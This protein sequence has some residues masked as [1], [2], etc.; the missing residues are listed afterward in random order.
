MAYGLARDL[1]RRLGEASTLLKTQPEHLGR[2]IETLLDENRRL[3]KRVEELL[4]GGGGGTAGGT[5]EQI[6]DVELHVDESDLDDRDQIALTMDAFR[7]KKRSAIRVLFTTG[8]R[9]GIHVAV[10]EDLVAKGVR[11]ATSPRRSPRATGGKG[12]GRAHF[13]SAGV[14]DAGLLGAARAQTPTIVRRFLKS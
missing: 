13:A 1:E 3:E 7:E 9:P 10:T 2:R 6:G 14:G 11:L 5:V 12:G 8:T 4:R